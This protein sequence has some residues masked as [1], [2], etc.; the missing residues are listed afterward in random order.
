MESN[1]WAG[2][3]YTCVSIVLF[4]IGGLTYRFAQT[5]TLIMVV[6]ASIYTL[7]IGNNLL[8]RDG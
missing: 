5:N 1:K 6:G 3:I 7:I 2:G 4:I 8:R